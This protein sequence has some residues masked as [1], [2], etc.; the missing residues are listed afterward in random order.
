M[1]PVQ[2]TIFGRGP[3]FGESVG[4]CFAACIASILEIPLDDVPNFCNSQEWVADLRAWLR[5]W[6]LYYLD[7]RIPKKDADLLDGYHVISGTSPRGCQH[8]VVGYHGKM[9][10]DPHPSG[11]GV[12]GELLFGLLV[13]SRP[14]DHEPREE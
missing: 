10:H 2:Q 1:I 3:D 4:N 7:V 6:G 12:S 8:S 9:V 13:L 14:V 11:D 5:P